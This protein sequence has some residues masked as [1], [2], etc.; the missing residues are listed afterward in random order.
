MGVYYGDRDA[1]LGRLRG[2]KVAVLG[3]DGQGQAH[4]LNLRDSQVDVIIG[5]DT[6]ASAEWSLARQDGWQPRTIPEAC[7]EADL[8]MNLLPDTEQG[9]LY[10]E[11]IAS[12]LRRG[13]SL[14]FF[15]GFAIRFAEIVPPPDIDVSLI[16]T[17]APGSRLRADFL[18]GVGTPA[19]VAVHQDSSGG[20][21]ADALAYAKGVGATRAG[22]LMTTFAEEVET[23]LFGEQAL[24][25]GG[26]PALVQ[27]AFHILVEAG[28]QPEVAY[29]RC[30]RDVKNIADLLYEG[31]VHY[32]HR[33]FSETAEHGGYVSEPKIVTDETRRAMREILSDAQSG[34]YAAGWLA[35][36]KTGRPWLLARRGSD[37]NSEVEQAGRALRQGMPD[38]RLRD[39]QSEAPE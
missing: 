37:R 25:C 3:Y 7:V 17:K 19:L 28:Y 18:A 6:G 9:H 31:G 22:I 30:V 29:L 33:N 5:V 26:L 15:H 36:L 10:R 2:R 34:F 27:S 16:A 4:A 12:C 24:L 38:L 21:L 20:A 11:K 14:L 8:I 1:D 35:E 32:M 23:D 39:V 13:K